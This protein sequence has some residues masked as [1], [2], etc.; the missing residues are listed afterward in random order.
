MNTVLVF[1]KSQVKGYSRKDGV[2]VKPHTTKVQAKPK[3]QPTGL[4]AKFQQ[5]GIATLLGNKPHQ[6][7][8]SAFS[9]AQA[10]LQ[11]AKKLQGLKGAS[12]GAA[13][14]TSGPV[15]PPKPKPIPKAY[16]PKQDDKHLPVGLYAPHQASDAA[17]WGDPEQVA[18]FT[19]GSTSRPHALY[20]VALKRWAD[21]PRTA[22]AW[23]RV[24]GQRPGLKEPPLPDPKGKHLSAGVVIEEE[25]GRVWTISPSNGFGG[26][27]TTFPKG[28]IEDGINPQASAI[29]E[30]FEESGL[31][32]EII[33]YLADVEP[34]QAGGRRPHR[35][36]LGEPGGASGAPCRIG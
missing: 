25:D 9:Y 24:D 3:P 36:G 2:Y 6:P 27:Q 4:D 14:P 32:V 21:H 11:A 33:G 17:T 22:A 30:A 28:T 19:P 35:H 23:N 7:G 15:A 12:Q 29:K 18:T 31:Q 8:G 20:G 16:H 34:R 13:K 1:A 26:Y 5:S 10:A